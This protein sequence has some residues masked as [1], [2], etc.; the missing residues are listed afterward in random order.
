MQKKEYIQGDLF[1]PEETGGISLEDVFTAYFDCRKHKRG[2]YNSLAFEVDYERKCVELWRQINAGTYHPARS[3][4]FIVFKPVLREVFAP[5]F[6]SRVVDHLIARKIEPLF[7]RQFIDN[8]F[9]TRKGKGT[10]YGINRVAEFIRC[11]SADYTQ[12]CYVMK[13]DIKSFFMSLP[14]QALYDKME[15]FILCHYHNADKHTLLYMLRAI[16]FDRPECHCLCRCPK[17]CWKDLPHNKSLFY[18]DGMHGMPIG[19]LTSQLSAAFALDPLDHLVCEKWGVPCYGRYVDDMVLVHKSKVHLIEV[20]ELIRR[21]LA[22][23]GFTLHPNKVYLQHFTKGVSFIGGKV[24]P[25][26]I[27]V[28]NRSL[29]FC[30]DAITRWNRLAVA[31]QGFAETHGEEFVAVINSYMGLMAHYNSYHIRCRICR[32]IGHEWWQVMYMSRGLHKAV[33][34]NQYKPITVSRR[35]IH[36]KLM[37][38][39]NVIGNNEKYEY[40]V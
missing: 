15:T 21:W 3:I 22:D 9:A 4:V 34:K 40:A 14:K 28:S 25:G 6:E 11:C 37:P 12:D 18:S 27:Y 8:S 31:E 16:I 33:L 24:M 10:L 26:R 35:Q 13:L 17:S 39:I 32:M 20:R 5:S 29:G 30:Y 36:C 2:T 19:R 23:N 7:E 38:K 1:S